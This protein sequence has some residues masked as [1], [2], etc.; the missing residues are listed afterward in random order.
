ML[1]LLLPALLFAGPRL[2]SASKAGSSPELTLLYPSIHLH[3]LSCV[4]YLHLY[5]LLHSL[6]ISLYQP[7]LVFLANSLRVFTFSLL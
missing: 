1:L 4:L 7:S 6:F 3:K 2:S 5:V